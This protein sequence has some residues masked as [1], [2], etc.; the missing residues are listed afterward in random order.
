MAA[1]KKKSSGNQASDKLIGDKAETLRPEEAKADRSKKK[2]E[3]PVKEKK[4]TFVEI[5]SLPGADDQQA[6]EAN[7]ILSEANSIS[8]EANKISAE[9][10]N[11][12]R[13]VNKN[14][15]RYQ[16]INVLL[17]VCTLVIAGTAIYSYT[18]SKTAAEIA[19]E[20]LDAA[21]S[22]QKQAL[23]SQKIAEN[24]KDSIE[25]EKFKRDTQLFN[26]QKR[27]VEA[28]ITS[29]KETQRQF[30]ISNG[31]YI[32]VNKFVFTKSVKKEHT[33]ITQFIIENVGNQPVKIL[34]GH[35]DFYDM[36]KKVYSYQEV[37]DSSFHKN[38]R[39]NI[40]YYLIKDNPEVITKEFDESNNYNLEKAFDQG[41]YDHY[42]YGDIYYKNLVTSKKGEYKFAVIIP[43]EKTPDG[44]YITIKNENTSLK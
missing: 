11:L 31:A 33:Y 34:Y 14:S 43:K 5:V 40:N 28:Q 6:I 2:S 12:S 32:Q 35:I 8:R 23:A 21:K 39:V 20:T 3:N 13:E 22:Y 38:T 44:G 19:K 42:I 17:L 4:R 29:L 27:S 36:Q 16:T 18:V 15:K 41:I 10:N 24:K 7:R 25:R 30:E 9:A 37:L 1:N 26:L